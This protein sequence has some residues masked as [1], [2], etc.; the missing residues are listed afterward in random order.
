MH[1]NYEEVTQGRREKRESADGRQMSKVREVVSVADWLT[2]K[3]EYINTNI[4]Y[5]KL[6]EKH[7]VSFATLRA[8]AKREDWI[9]QKESQQHK[10]SAKIAQKAADVVVRKEVNRIKKINTLADA[11]LS[12]LEEATEQLNNHLVA[13]KTKTRVIEYKDPA[14]PGKPTKETIEENE[15]KVFIVGDIDRAGLKQLT[16]A[17]KDLK[18]VQIAAAANPDPGETED[19]P[20]TAAIKEDFK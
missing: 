13:N 9:A 17:L 7:N 15:E 16:A 20:I 4:S 3:N 12:K 6:A 10:V 5:R 14:A 1:S 8:R 11:L 18:D 19:D 2:I